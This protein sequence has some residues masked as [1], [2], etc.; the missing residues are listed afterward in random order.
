[1]SHPTALPMRAGELSSPRGLAAPAEKRVRT[2]IVGTGRL[3]VSVARS[4]AEREDRTLLGAVDTERLPHLEAGLPSVAWLGDLGDL[5]SIALAHAADELCVALPLRSGF[6]QWNEVRAVGLELGLPVSLHLDL[7]GDA[8]RAEIASAGL[9]TLV[10][11]N[12]HPSSRRRSALAKRAFDLVAGSLALLVL[13]PVLLV[14]AALV[15]GTSPG[16]VFFRQP[17][18]GRGRRTFGMLKLRTMTADAEQ[19]RAEVSGLNDASGIMFKIERDP[20]LTAV[21]PMLRRTSIDELPQLWNVLRGEMSL[22]GPRPIPLWVFEQID[23]P[24]FHRRFSVL[25]GMTG[26]WQVRGRP[27]HYTFMA[28]HDLEYVERWSLWLDLEILA[29]TVPAVLKRKGAL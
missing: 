21:G 13:S 25:P 22:V 23:D 27:Q 5:R 7:I 15:K 14:A 24:S 26:L 6:D 16:P 10:R 19:R 28:R 17:R 11:C 20:R 2:I 8:G 12:V 3:A 18:V 4:L 1:M 29:R 9:T